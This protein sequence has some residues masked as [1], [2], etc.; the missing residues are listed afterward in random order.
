MVCQNVNKV[1]VKK[2]L[3]LNTNNK[4]F[5]IPESRRAFV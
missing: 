4:F 3:L 2:C 5:G 1:N